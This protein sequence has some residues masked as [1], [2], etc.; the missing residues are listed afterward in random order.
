MEVYR[1]HKERNTDG[2]IHGDGKCQMAE[3]MTVLMT[4]L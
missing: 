4:T 2:S 1:K 3:V